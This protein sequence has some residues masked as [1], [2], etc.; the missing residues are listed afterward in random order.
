MALAFNKSVS[1]QSWLPL[2]SPGEFTH[3]HSHAHTYTHQ[4]P[5]QTNRPVKTEC[6]AVGPG[7]QYF[8]KFPRV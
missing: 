6:L 8:L 4:G 3:T 7:Y 1:A 5:L 2:E